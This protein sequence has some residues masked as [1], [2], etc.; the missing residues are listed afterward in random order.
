MSLSNK[1]RTHKI[2][3]AARLCVPGT[4]NQ[5][6]PDSP[7]VEAMTDFTRVSVVTIQADATIGAANASMIARGVRMLLVTATDGQLE[8]LI[9]ARDIQGERPVQLSQQR[10][11]KPADLLVS[12]IMVK[13]NDIDIVYF[14]DVVYARVA[15][16]LDS[17]KV[18]GRQHVLVEDIDPAS[19]EAR[20]RGVFSA[21][22][23]GRLLGVPVQGFEVARTFAEIEAALAD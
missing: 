21:T 14:R 9:T 19:G 4:Y 8:G 5:V 18:Q 22:Q 6:G 11:V 17:M 7:A 12:D 3:P 16:I 23:I 10:G 20:V 2:S 15:D 1:V 13:A